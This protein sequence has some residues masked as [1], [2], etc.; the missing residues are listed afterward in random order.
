M[1]LVERT[2][3][4]VD[5]LHLATGQNALQGGLF[6]TGIVGI[7]VDG[8]T[9]TLQ[10]VDGH[11]EA[12]VVF[13]HAG[14]LV[15][16][17]TFGQDGQDDGGLEGLVLAGLTAVLTEELVVAG[18]GLRSWSGRRRSFFG[19]GDAEET[20]ALELVTAFQFGVGSDEFGFGDAVFATD[21]VDRLLALHLVH[22]AA[23]GTEFPG[24]LR[25]LWLG[26]RGRRGQGIVIG[27]GRN[28]DDLAGTEVLG[29]ETGVGGADGLY[30]DAVV[31][32]EAV[33][34]FSGDDGVVGFLGPAFF[35]TRDAQGAS[36]VYLFIAAG[37][38]ADDVGLADAVHAGDGIEALPFLNGMQKIGLV[39]LCEEVQAPRGGQQQG[40][41]GAF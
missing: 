38:Q 4:D 14:R 26:G 16:L 6:G 9:G 11:E 34:R 5:V 7:E 23:V 22:V 36:D 31:H 29:I 24:L 32:T 28:A 21:A 12:F 2:E 17:G 19:I 33:E 18:S 20:A 1:L 35:L 41:D 3:D 15:A 30:A 8:H 37:V 39:L 25:L 27:L 40:K 10:A 13:H